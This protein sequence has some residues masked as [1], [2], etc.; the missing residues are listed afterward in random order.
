MSNNAKLLWEKVNWTLT[1]QR[2]TNIQKRIYKHSK[3]GNKGMVTFLQNLLITSLDAKL[4]AVRRVT[5]ENKGKFTPGVDLKIYT[6]PEEKIQLVKSLKVD[7]KAVPIR[8]VWIPKPGKK[9]MRPLGIPIIKDRAKQKLVLMALEPEWEAKFEPNSY[10]F[11]PGRSCQDAI[12]AIFLTMRKKG[13]AES[14]KHV[15]DADLKG[16]FD[17][18][19]HDY[20]INKL[21]T[22]TRIANQIRAWLKAGIFEGLSLEPPYPD[23]PPNEK[24]TPQGGIISPFLS[25]VALHGMETHLKEWIC[26]QTWAVSKRHQLYKTNK[27]KSITLVRYADDFVVIHKNK[28][29][30]LKAQEALQEWLNQTSKLKF[31]TEKTKVVD[32]NQGFNFLG[33]SIITHKRGKTSKCKIYPSKKNVHRI[34]KNIGETCRKF[35]SISTYDLID[36]LRPKIFGWANYYKYCE[37]QKTFCKV[38]NAIFNILRSWVFRR[39]RR[40][41]RK[42]IKEKYFPNGRTYSFDKRTYKDNWVLVGRKK[43]KGGKI[44]EKWL[45]KI[46]WVKSA[47]YIKV[48]ST[49]SV[50]DTN[51]AYWA[52]RTAK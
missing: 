52:L 18:I 20:L 38:N 16:C 36:I 12:E 11:R 46:T 2:V 21:N 22:S 42:E 23:I 14:H 33:F 31:N 34:I 8:R 45:P 30:I 32:S 44:E 35:R 13:E 25:N 15:L 49:N 40:H 41:G 24:G 6:T 27:I 26:N 7:G 47:K 51:E 1:E 19:D 48:A 37:C 17:N 50:Y 10:G 29:I 39:D 9:D 3:L 5:V 43:V 28:D 4:L